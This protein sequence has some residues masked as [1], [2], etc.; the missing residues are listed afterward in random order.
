MGNYQGESYARYEGNSRSL[1]GGNPIIETFWISVTYCQEV[2][3]LKGRLR[4]Y[5]HE[6]WM[7]TGIF[8]ITGFLDLAHPPVF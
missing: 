5:Q 2:K 1:Q 7:S 3:V 8:G 6:V 4:G